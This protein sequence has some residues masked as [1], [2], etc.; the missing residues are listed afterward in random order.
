M[1]RADPLSRYWHYKHLTDPAYKDRFSFYDYNFLVPEICRLGKTVRTIPN[2][3]YAYHVDAG[4][5]GEVL[6]EVAKKHGVTQ[7]IDMVTQVNQ[8]EDGS[9]RSL[10]RQNGPELE[11][12]LFIDCSGFQALLMDKTLKEPFD[13][14][15]DSLF[16]NKAVAL[17]IPYLDKDVEMA[18][19]TNCNALSSGWAWTIPLYGRLGTGYVYCGDYK[20][21]DQA[22]QELRQYLGE[23]RTKDC[24]AKHIDIRV[25]K[26]RRTWVK[27]CVAIGLA[28]GFI[29]PLESTGLFIVQGA[30]QL[31]TNILVKNNDY[32]AVDCKVYNDS[33]TRLLEI[34]R[35]FLVCHYA[36][37][38]RE[39][40]P[41]WRDVKYTTK[42]PDSLSEKLQLARLV[43]P[44]VQHINRFDNA[45]LAGFSFNEGWQCILTGQDY[46]PFAWD[47]L[48][49]NQVGPFDPHILANMHVADERKRQKDQQKLQARQM[50]SHYQFLKTNYY[51]GVE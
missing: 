32:N 27:N 6:K 20:T 25:G 31:L 5:W 28:A 34:I 26:H 9:I 8:H 24:W 21:P 43:M 46:L 7:V 22:E 29:E 1:W 36:L 45:S 13:D 15:Y 40:S 39:D 49:R 3:S 18:S 35:D 48:K 23:E 41:Y 19:Y 2:T 50:P 4:L 44:D 14:F 37:T 38:E 10:S 33:V 12:D 42:I 17:R 47:Q 30:V 16:N 51:K 11:A